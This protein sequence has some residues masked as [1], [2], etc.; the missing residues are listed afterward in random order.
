M[1]AL[2]V[3]ESMFGNTA[4]VANAVAEGL[5]GA[6]EVTLADVRERPPVAGVD[7]LVVGAPTHAFGLSRP[8]TRA[9]AGKQ[10]EV[11]AGARETGI[12]EYLDAAS[13]LAGLPVAAF[14]TRM[15]TRFPTGSA[16]RKALRRLHGL[17][18]Q[19]V[20]PAEDFRVGGMTGPLVAGEIERARRWARKVADRH[21]SSAA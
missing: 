11:R 2:V 20:V 8:S 16:A 15:D 7:L 21:T 4:A 9:D 10:G 18:G 13:P 5:A 6:F 14:D 3:Y 19:P 1:R 17:G 12:R